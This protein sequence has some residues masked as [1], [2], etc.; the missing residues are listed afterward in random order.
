MRILNILL[1][2]STLLAFF[3]CAKDRCD[4]PSEIAEIKVDFEAQRLEKELFNAKSKEEIRAFLN[5]YPLFAD[6]FLQRKHYQTEEE[7]VNSL[8]GMVTEPSLKQLAAEADERFKDMDGLEAD[9]E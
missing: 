1:L 8:Y 9:L 3:G 4:I 7:L 5:K 6:R 2:C